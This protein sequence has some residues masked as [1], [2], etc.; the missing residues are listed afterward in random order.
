MRYG[1]AATS[2]VMIEQIRATVIHMM[3]QGLNLV[4]LAA[5]LRQHVRHSPEP[6]AVTPD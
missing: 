5:V 3:P 4:L 1:A 6:F 2:Y